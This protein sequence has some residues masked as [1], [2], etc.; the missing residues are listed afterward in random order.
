MENHTTVKKDL[1][2]YY[3]SRKFPPTPIWGQLSEI[4]DTLLGRWG[5]A[6]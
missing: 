2:F 1:N 6:S 3:R 4:M 5:R